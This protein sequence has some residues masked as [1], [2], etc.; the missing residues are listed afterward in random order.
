MLIFPNSKIDFNQTKL[1]TRENLGLLRLVER[2]LAHVAAW[3]TVTSSQ[4]EPFSVYIKSTIKAVG[5]TSP[6]TTTNLV[7]RRR[8][9]SKRQAEERISVFD[10]ETPRELKGMKP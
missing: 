1:F 9:S 6:T 7:G 10:H 4:S 8:Q 2:L 5:N 3:A